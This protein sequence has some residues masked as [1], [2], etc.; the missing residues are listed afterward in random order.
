MELT[1]SS[2]NKKADRL[3]CFIRGVVDDFADTFWSYTR[4]PYAKGRARAKDDLKAGRVI[5]KTFGPPA[6]WRGIYAEIL[7]SEYGVTLEAVADGNIS[8]KQREEIRGYN[9]VVKEELRK[10]HGRDFLDMVI[11]R[12]KDAFVREEERKNSRR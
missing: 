9:S 5:L 7:K 8:A 2:P 12:A 1:E 6:K 4:I 11:E 3:K 10:R